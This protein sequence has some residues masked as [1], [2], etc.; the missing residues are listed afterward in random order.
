MGELLPH[1]VLRFDF[2][3]I[4]VEARRQERVDP[5]NLGEHKLAS[6][7]HAYFVNQIIPMVLQNDRVYEAASA[8]VTQHADSYLQRLR[9]SGRSAFE[10]QTGLRELWQKVIGFLQTLP[11][12]ALPGAT[13]SLMK[14]SDFMKLVKFDELSS[15]AQ[16]EANSLCRWAQDQ[17]WY[18]L[19]VTLGK[20]AD[21]YEMGLPRVMFV[22]QRAM[23]VQ[24][25]RAPKNTDG[26]LLAPACYI[27][28][29]SSSAGDGHPLYPILGDHGLVEFYRVARNVANHHKGLEWEP[30]TD[31][32]G[33]KDRGTTLAVH[34]QAF[35]QRERYL[36]YICDY[37]LRA[38]W[39]AF[40]ER[41]KGAISDD[42]FDKYNNTFPKDFPSGEGARVRYYTRP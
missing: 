14:P 15:R 3:A 13:V 9:E 33:L 39:S 40:C 35:Q 41:E 42:L 28:W 6:D 16:A 29:F 1:E 32:V 23:K 10:A 18:H 7:I 12:K 11:P 5:A 36:V 26:E 34:V 2:D 27:D 24:S 17:E 38:I 19:N 31:Q 37:G 21:T 4:R 25:G 30:G 8:L 22:V 20:I